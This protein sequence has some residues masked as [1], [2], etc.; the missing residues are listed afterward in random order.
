MTELLMTNDFFWKIEKK[1][2]VCIWLI[3]LM[4]WRNSTNFDLTN[5]KG[6]NFLKTPIS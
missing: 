1:N 5:L 6:I 2:L 3:L 4:F